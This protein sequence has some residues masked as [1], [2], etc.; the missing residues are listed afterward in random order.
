[1]LIRKLDRASMTRSGDVSMQYLYPWDDV[2]ATPFG[3]AWAVVKPGETSHAHGHHEGETFFIVSGSGRL[4]AGDET[5]AVEAGD[6]VYFP[7]FTAHELTNDTATD[8]VFLTVF[9]ESMRDALAHAAAAPAA[10]PNRARTIVTSTPP[11][12]NGDL[13]LGHL[14]GP[15][16]GADVHVRYLRM[17]GVEAYHLSGSDV[18]QSYVAFKAAQTGTTPL[19]VAERYTGEIERTLA[20]VGALPDQFT[21]PHELAGYAQAVTEFY[22]ELVA[23]GAIVRERAPALYCETCASYRYEAYVGGRCPHCGAGC[24]GNFC[25]ECARPNDCVT[26]AGAA[27]KVCGAQPAVRKVERLYVRLG[28]YAERL[29]AHVARSPMNT[30]LRA[31]SETM[32]ENPLPSIAVS[33]PSAWGLPVP[34]AGFDEQTIW[35]WLEMAVGYLAGMRELGRRF[36]WWD[37]SAGVWPPPGTQ[38]VQFMGIDNGYYHTLLFPLLYALLRP[39]VDLPTTYVGNEFYC[40]DGAKF[41]TSR[42]HAV[43]GREMLGRA[44]RDEVRFYLAWTRPEVAQ[45][46][47]T[48]SDFEV[49]IRRELIDG[50]QGWLRELDH[51]VRRDFGGC[52]P[53]PGYWTEDHRRFLDRIAATTARAAEAY[54][55]ATFSPQRVT[56]ALSE[57]AREARALG[58]AEENWRPVRRRYDERRTAVALEL[59]AAT[60]L[61]RLCAPIMPDFAQRLWS[62]LGNAGDVAAAW[63]EQPQWVA[64]G[65]EVQLGGDYFPPPGEAVANPVQAAPQPVPA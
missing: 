55:A 36:G 1:M 46:S 29:R 7:P 9:W 59:A 60:A 47:F 61:A 3:S 22:A 16:L 56:R 8:L 27:C 38:L 11:T 57:L 43:W 20:A 45:T 5:C 23:C 24:N 6:V 50:L 30:H 41:S 2:V 33:H 44:T 21:R 35:V 34:V 52:A 65:T 18:Y 19:E 37:E 12:P 58:A 62:D 13:H 31:L 15:Y 63:P 40:L 42:N 51:R 10:A 32:L 25:E 28:D 39:N 17:R 4:R 53:E 64:F 14:S 49:T 48:A 54:E 26:M